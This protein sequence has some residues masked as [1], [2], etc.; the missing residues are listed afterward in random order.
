MSE[1]IYAKLHYI[2]QQIKAPKSKHNDF[3]GYNFRSQEDILRAVKPLLRE[4]K[5]SIVISDEI[6]HIGERYYLK[7]K[8][9][10]L[11]IN[12]GAEITAVAYAREQESR[13]KMDAAQLTGA[14]SSYARKYALSGLLA[15]DNSKDADQINHFQ[16]E[17]ENTCP[18]ES[19]S[20]KRN[21]IFFLGGIKEA[22]NYIK[23]ETGK[24]KI[25][26]K[27]AK[28]LYQNLQKS[29]LKTGEERK[30]YGNSN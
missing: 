10:I 1:G 22:Q 4:Q 28:Q 7:A 18:P 15:I 20:W 5:V 13:K 6:V 19:D 16:N 2:Q 14:A 3:G 24:A 12:N 26:E 11:D 8:A 25:S 29:H 23:Q 30:Y 9:S 21:L 17:T 27:E